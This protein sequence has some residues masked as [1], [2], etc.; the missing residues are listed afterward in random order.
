MAK[1][2]EY[3]IEIRP[4]YNNDLTLL[5]EIIHAFEF[6]LSGVRLDNFVTVRLFVELSYKIPNLSELINRDSHLDNKEHTTLFLLKSL[7]L[8]LELNLKSGTIYAYGRED[9]L[10]I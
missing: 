8:D 10:N 7:K 3:L 6:M 4:E 5:H 1:K 2:Y 9:L